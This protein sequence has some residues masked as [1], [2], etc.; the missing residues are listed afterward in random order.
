M[1]RP[2]RGEDEPPLTALEIASGIVAGRARRALPIAWPDGAE[3]AVDA[4]RNGFEAS[5]RA[6]LRRPPCLV[7]FSGGL[8]S[9]TV[10]AAATAVARREGLAPPVPITWRFAKVAA[11]D[12]TSWQ[13]Q[14]IAG[15]GLDDWVRLEGGE[16]LDFVGPV[17]SRLIARHGVRYPANA[18]LHLPLLERA[19][20]G[21]LLTGVGGDE[22]L[23]RWRW[24]HS[25]RGPVDVLRA[26]TPATL[27]RMRALHAGDQPFA[28]LRPRAAGVARWQ[29]TGDL[30]DPADWTRRICWQAG[31]RRLALALQTLAVLGEGADCLVCSPFTAP[32]FLG[33]AGRAGGR[34]GLGP[35]PDAM[36][37]LLGDL[38]P[39]ALGQRRSKARFGDA[40]WTARARAAAAAWRGGAVD[41]AIVDS[42]G[43][44]Q[45]WG[46]AEP[47][48]RTALLL[49]HTV[50]SGCDGQCAGRGL[51]GE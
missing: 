47:Q 13:E 46:R 38:V 9:S 31:R 2:L 12:E 27:R 16:Q 29:A 25:A 5:V 8:D 32:A 28:W 30:G 11:T 23:G 15:L 39:R 7:S 22:L 1:G 26:R 48:L 36:R 51:A 49:Q 34:S 50:L 42:A 33:A 41:T 17:A 24:Q 14:V 45:V 4:A 20:G 43:L 3:P 37:T 10:L 44:R 40:L 35:R 21:S 19:A 18:H 6:A